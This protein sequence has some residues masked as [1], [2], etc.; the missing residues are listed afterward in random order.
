MICPSCQ[1]N[2]VVDERSFGALFTCKNCQAVYFI[3]FDGQPE[4]SDIP[5][6]LH[7]Q[8]EA[9]HPSSENLNLD[10]GSGLGFESQVSQNQ[11]HP[12]VPVSGLY[13]LDPLNSNNHEFINNSDKHIS[14]SNNSDGSP[15]MSYNPD[16]QSYSSF[17][18][19]ESVNSNADLNLDSQVKS[20][21]SNYSSSFAAAA[22][23]ITEYGNTESQIAQLNYS[24]KLMGLDTVEIK[25]LLKEAIDD[26]RF[27][28]DVGEVMKNIKN[29]E[30]KFE[31]LN[32]VKAFILAKRLHFLDVEKIWTQNAVG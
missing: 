2:Q 22:N 12:Q 20:Q 16:F 10:L 23:E 19:L 15:E 11:L 3:N 13:S 6:V 27:G 5:P 17:E 8:D 30:I 21:M 26:S 9:L 1:I 28:W 25:N 24:L 31:E 29:G 14:D 7:Q 32:P 4:Y 18:T